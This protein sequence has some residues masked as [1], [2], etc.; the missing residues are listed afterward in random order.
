MIRQV[1]VFL[2]NKKGRMA[3]LTDVL[4]Q[5]N[6]NLLSLSIADTAQFGIL[7]ALV[8]DVDAAVDALHK[9]GFTVNVASVLACEVPDHPGG[10]ALVLKM[11]SIADIGVEYLYSFAHQPAQKALIVFRVDQPEKA[12]EILAVMGCHMISEQELLTVENP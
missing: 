6:V 7:R 4:A 5:A 11:L 1:S 12:A 2:E 8:S 10:L 9:E 3:H